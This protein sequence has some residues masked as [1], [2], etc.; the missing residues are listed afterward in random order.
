MTLFDITHFGAS[1]ITESSREKEGNMNKEKT[2][3]IRTIHIDLACNNPACFQ[4][5]RRLSILDSNANKLFH[6]EYTTTL[7][8]FLEIKQIAEAAIEQQKEGQD[9]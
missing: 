8:L 6:S 4:H 3:D 9:E 5:P 1:V 2:K 7:D